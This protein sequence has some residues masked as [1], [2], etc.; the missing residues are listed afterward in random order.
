MKITEAKVKCPVCNWKGTLGESELDV[1][2]EGSPGC[3][4]CWCSLIMVRCR[5]K[6][7]E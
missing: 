4:L 2:G 7:G 5:V 3:P 6:G 1:D